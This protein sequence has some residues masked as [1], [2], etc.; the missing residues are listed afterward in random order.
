MLYLW[1]VALC[2][3]LFL[4]MILGLSFTLATGLIIYHKQISEGM[5]DEHR[6]DILFPDYPCDTSLSFCVSFDE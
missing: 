2:G 1:Q 3:F 6:Y 5:Q 4:G